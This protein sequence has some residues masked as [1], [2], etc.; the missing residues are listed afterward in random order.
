MARR[1]PTLPWS[2]R[3]Q[4]PIER[5]DALAKADGFAPDVLKIDVQGGELQVL[6][7]AETSLNSTLLAEVEV[8]YFTRYVG[9]PL[10]GDIANH[11]EARGFELIDLL[12]IKRYRAA[13]SAGI[14]NISAEAGDRSGR[15]AYGN[16]IFLRREADLLDRARA[17]HGQTLL[18]AI[19]ALTAYG[20]ADPRREAVRPRPGVPPGRDDPNALA[21]AMTSFR[22]NGRARAIAWLRSRLAG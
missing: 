18:K 4:V 8:S 13:N 10:Y 11:M 9:Q 21:T 3:K 22:L 5:L 12:S 20:K 17:D 6:A 14:R 19:V 1:M 7:G 15:A 2:R 16:A